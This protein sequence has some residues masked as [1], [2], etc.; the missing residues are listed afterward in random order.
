MHCLTLKVEGDA[1]V[2]H[3]ENARGPRAR[4]LSC[5]DAFCSKALSLLGLSIS[6]QSHDSLFLSAF[7][8]PQI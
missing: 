4:F 7:S 6:L 8:C 2:L 3:R 5:S 1:A